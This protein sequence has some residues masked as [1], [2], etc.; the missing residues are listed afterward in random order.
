MT[1]KVSMG[2]GLRMVTKV[3]AMV[4]AAFPIEMTWM[5]VERSKRWFSIKIFLVLGFTCIFCF[6]RACGWI[7]SKSLSN[8]VMICFR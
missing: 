8:S 5:F 2:M 3:C 7:C 6:K 4:S 1:T